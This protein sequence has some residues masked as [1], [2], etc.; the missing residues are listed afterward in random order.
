MG[1]YLMSQEI[2]SFII[3]ELEKSGPINCD[4]KL[5][6]NFLKTG[7]IDSLG[8]MKFIVAL[9]QEFDITFTDE[10]LT[11]E[12]FSTVST[13]SQLIENSRSC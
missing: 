13:L 8:I 2:T 9:E 1:R 6:F 3:N 4:D 12:E 10:E 11:S 7:H 5:S